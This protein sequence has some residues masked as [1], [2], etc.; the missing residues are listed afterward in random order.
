MDL[1]LAQHGGNL[2]AAREAYPLAPEPWLD[3]STGISPHAYPF[4]PLPVETFTRLPDP[5]AIAAL[6]ASATRFY[7]AHDAGTV[8]AA[9]GTQA[10]IQW[11]PRLLP[12]RRV[13]ILGFT[14]GEYARCFAAAG[15]EVTVCDGVDALADQDVGVIVNPNNPDGRRVPLAA[16]IDLAGR[17]AAHGG[18]LVVDEA[19]ADLDEAASLVPRLPSSG[20]IVL[21]SFGKSFGLAGVRLG[22]AIAAPPLIEAIR[23]AIGPW[24]VSGA[25][26]AIAEAAFADRAWLGATRARLRSDGAELDRII[27]QAGFTLLGGTPLFRL[28][29]HDDAVGIFRLLA[30]AGI[31]VRRFTQEPAWLRFGIPGSEAERRRLAAALAGDPA[32]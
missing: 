29:R 13:G 3:L 27:E 32:G 9:A 5:A 17:L 22:F 26:V 8:V 6:E 21:R 28:A 31:L 15:A 19:F 2:A 25:A 12:A 1:A 18:T 24:A 20:A 23:L 10:L 11:L 7:G 4:T 16:L 14:Y 30:Q